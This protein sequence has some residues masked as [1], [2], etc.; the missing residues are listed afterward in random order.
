MSSVELKTYTGG[1]RQKWVFTGPFLRSSTD[2][3]KVLEF[4]PNQS[5][6]LRQFENR[7]RQKFSSRDNFL[8]PLNCSLAEC[9]DRKYSIGVERVFF[10][11]VSKHNAKVLSADSSS[12]TALVAYNRND[13]QLW[14]WDGESIR[15][16]QYPSRVITARR[17]RIL[18]QEWRYSDEQ[19]LKYKDNRIY[20]IT[21]STYLVGDGS[22]LTNSWWTLATEPRQYFVIKSIVDAKVLNL[23]PPAGL[24]IEQKTGADN[25]L[26]FW[27]E[28]LIRSKQT[29]ERVIT[30]DKRGRKFLVD[31]YQTGQDQEFIYEDEAISLENQNLFLENSKLG[32]TMKP[33][34]STSSQQWTLSDPELDQSFA[35]SNGFEGRYLC[36]NNIGHLTACSDGN[37]GDLF[38]VFTF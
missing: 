30:F 34:A 35:I 5:V 13:N 37:S 1:S 9:R 18:L 16:K 12:T 24:S 33:K 15:S 26:W 32:I 22:G 29:P 36:V 25:Q 31:F 14:F 20:T 8:M 3:T 4:G 19:R 38:W 7:D 11:I 27:D 21:E 17:N 28:N 10:H 2:K 6:K 23:N